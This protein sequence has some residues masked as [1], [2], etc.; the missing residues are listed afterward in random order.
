MNCNVTSYFQYGTPFPD[1]FPGLG[2]DFP[3]GSEYKVILKGLNVVG[4]PREFGSIGVGTEQFGIQNVMCEHNFFNGDSFI[5]WLELQIKRPPIDGVEQVFTT[6]RAS[7]MA[8]VD[9]D[10]SKVWLPGI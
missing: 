5:I 7:G 6:F 3:V 8:F 2:A 10:P 1:T 4:A 9:F